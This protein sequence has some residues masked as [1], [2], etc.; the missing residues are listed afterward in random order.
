MFNACRFALLILSL[1]VVPLV[2]PLRFAVAQDD[3]DAR[4]RAFIL[5]NPEII[6]EAMTILSEREEQAQIV[7]RLAKFPD[8]FADDFGLGIGWEGAP[9]HVIEFF[10]Y[11]CAPCKAMHPKLLAVSALFPELRI[12]MRHLPILSPGS[13]RAARFA[14][15]TQD[16]FGE[17]A[18]TRVHDRLWTTKGPLNAAAFE[19]IAKAEGLDFAAIEPAMDAAKITA[20]IDHNRDIA[21]ALEIL[22]TPGFVSP[23]SVTVGDTDPEALVKLWLNR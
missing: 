17:Q 4:V 1:A 11:R 14:L 7:A 20:R 9:T 2:M 15:A 23:N 8:L 19:R 3:F 12:E 5:D 22:G 6:L 10:D 16:I 13:E 18:Y 21:I